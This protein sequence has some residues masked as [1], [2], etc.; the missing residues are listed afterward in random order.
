[1]L[2]NGF[3]DYQALR[4]SLEA[5]LPK[6]WEGHFYQEADYFTH[7]SS[8]IKDDKYT[9]P[10]PVIGEWN[11]PVD[12]IEPAI[13]CCI[14][15]KTTLFRVYNDEGEDKLQRR[16]PPPAGTADACRPSHRSAHRGLWDKRKICERYLV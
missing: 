3:H 15:P 13:L 1:M 7:T 12:P 16:Y 9:Y 5:V 4:T 10:L 11:Y 2:M 8:S 14:A 6:G